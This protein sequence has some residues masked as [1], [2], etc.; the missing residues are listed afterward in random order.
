MV[1]LAA[2]TASFARRDLDAD[3]LGA[4]PAHS[5]SSSSSSSSR[6]DEARLVH[7]K[8]KDKKKDKKKMLNR[9]AT[10]DA[11]VHVC[12]GKTC[13]RRGSPALLASMA[14]SAAGR[15]VQVQPSKCQGYC[16]MG[17]SVRIDKGGPRHVQY[18]AVSPDD[19]QELLDE[20]AA[21]R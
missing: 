15:G 11:T 3:R 20:A 9:A 13:S 16:K 6:D 19:I 7:K 14:A 5:S 4:Q 18:A 8:K 10:Q 17:P 12:Q 1:P 21:G 2:Y